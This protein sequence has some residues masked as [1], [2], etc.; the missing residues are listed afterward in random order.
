[1]NVD[2][3]ILIVDE[4]LAVGDAIFQ[5]RCF[6]KIREMQEAGK[7]ILYVGHDTE[8]V[9][10]LCTSALLLDA[11][12]IIERGDPNT[13]VNKYYALIAEREQAYTEGN[14]IEH[15]EIPGEGYETVYDFVQ[16]LHEAKIESAKGIQVQPQTVEI[17]STPRRVI[18]AHPPSLITYTVPIGPG[19]SLAFAIGILPGAWDKIPQGVKFDIEVVSDGATETLFSRVLQP[20][21]NI[22]DRGWHNF[23]VP[24][25]KY[26]GKT[27]C[28]MFSTSGS[29]DDM[30][31]GWS[32]WGWGKIICT[33]PEKKELEIEKIEFFNQK[34]TNRVNYGN[35]R[36]EFIKIEL[37]DQNGNPK[38]IFRSGELSTINAS[39]VFNDDI[40]SDFVVGYKIFSK[41]GM[42]YG[43]CTL[44]EDIVFKKH[45]KGD[46]VKIR[47]TQILCLAPGF[48]SIDFDIATAVFPANDIEVLNTVSNVLLF[49]IE[50]PKPFCGV[51]D[52]YSK[53]QME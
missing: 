51:I 27:V 43:T 19:S 50:S 16:N 32:A 9:R 12:R 28:L 1:V 17:L 3:D 41:F 44:W 35:K 14:L 22:G 8:A 25:E 7:T 31:Y 15:G 36:A 21:R 11:G 23:I 45:Q 37:L 39:I 5:H 26:Y 13:V 20:K 47:F 33:C 4:A 52:L 40:D 34:I 46:I 2:A 42:I 10:N 6:R 38:Y 48:Y 29:G 49:Q 53:I 24:L 18:F 30:S